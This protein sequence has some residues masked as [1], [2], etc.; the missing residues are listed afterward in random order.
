MS[1]SS[2]KIGEHGVRSE[3]VSQDP[4]S[5]KDNQT[6][7]LSESVADCSEAAKSL[8]TSIATDDPNKSAPLRKKLEG[9]I[10]GLN[11]FVLDDTLAPD[12]RRK[13]S[14][15]QE[16]MAK[17]ITWPDR[18]LK[19]LLTKERSLWL[20]KDAKDIRQFAKDNPKRFSQFVKH[21]TQIRLP[22]EEDGGMEPLLTKED[23]GYEQV[24]RDGAPGGVAWEIPDEGLNGGK[25][26]RAID[27]A[28]Q[29]LKRFAALTGL[30]QELLD[31]PVDIETA[32]FHGGVEKLA[33]E[34]SKDT[35]RTGF[36]YQEKGL[37]FAKGSLKAVWNLSIG[38]AIEIVR[39]IM[40]EKSD[41]KSTAYQE[42]LAEASIDRSDD[43]ALALE[44]VALGAV[45]L[46]A[47]EIST[48]VG[49]G[50]SR[51]RAFLSLKNMKTVG[52][53]KWFKGIGKG[54]SIG[55]LE[56]VG[57][58]TQ[59][60]ASGI[61]AV[62]NGVKGAGIRIAYHVKGGNPVYESVMSV[63]EIPDYILSDVAV[64]MYRGE[65]RFYADKHD[66]RFFKVVRDFLKRKEVRVIHKE[67][68]YY[69]FQDPKN[70]RLGVV[71]DD[72]RNGVG[73]S[74]YNY[75]FK[76]MNKYYRHYNK[77]LLDAEIIVRDGDIYV[78]RVNEGDKPFVRIM[79]YNPGGNGYYDLDE[80]YSPSTGKYYS[81]ER[82]EYDAVVF[83]EGNV[84]DAGLIEQLEKSLD[85]VALI[86][87]A[88]GEI[89]PLENYF[90]IQK[91]LFTDEN[92]Y[93]THSEHVPIRGTDFFHLER[94]SPVKWGSR[95]HDGSGN[96]DNI[97]IVKRDVDGQFRLA[98]ESE[99]KTAEKSLRPSNSVPDYA[100]P[101]GIRRVGEVTADKK[102]VGGVGIIAFEQDIIIKKG[103]H[104]YRTR[105]SAEV[106]NEEKFDG[107]MR[108]LIK[109]MKRLP[110]VA[111]KRVQKY[112]F[113]RG[114]AKDYGWGSYG[115]LYH[116]M[117][118][119]VSVYRLGEKLNLET[120]RH[121]VAGHGSTN[122]RDKGSSELKGRVML[123][124]QASPKEV[125]VF[126]KSEMGDYFEVAWRERFAE[127]V[128]IYM[129]A[130]KRELFR[131]MDPHMTA[132]IE[133]VFTG[134]IKGR[135]PREE[136]L[137]Q[138]LRYQIIRGSILTACG[139]GLGI[140]GYKIAT[141]PA[142]IRFIKKLFTRNFE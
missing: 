113:Y 71:Q 104:R 14:D 115:G 100:V 69:L 1:N 38:G 15:Q 43:I 130:S 137:Y 76:G 56:I 73:H 63:D 18:D 24:F 42:A 89:E 96:P 16:K 19:K 141:D 58:D 8:F 12:V 4:I 116:V 119:E 97:F 22:R 120:L 118:D 111:L 105:V 44:G 9:K 98:T 99:I 27:D 26:Y 134:K 60:L 94:M 117:D 59:I 88:D 78:V 28:I 54:A 90:N 136:R 29:R 61:K 80:Y 127:A 77:E 48:M 2:V 33:K 107:L 5:I 108:D 47:P 92:G 132:V 53:V 102:I 81:T 140:S 13:I 37:I 122:F 85:S 11:R 110:M 123:A 20:F 125:D 106:V 79:E 103:M 93:I 121:E 55:A 64:E 133:D 142:F 74:I 84:S 66:E 25:Y 40:A 7:T 41:Q 35:Y 62:A 45:A 51:M 49:K 23:L 17:L 131:N 87:R 135:T 114:A 82:M 138:E 72:H 70:G 112:H 109:E 91:G 3:P 139:A 83:D 68:D 39:Y 50:F 75:Y 57:V 128:A 46:Y 95:V 65:G 124:M 101:S 129:D 30:D 52:P 32:V 86:R 67:G 36:R 6:K 10:K 21:L 34:L 31:A 126:Y